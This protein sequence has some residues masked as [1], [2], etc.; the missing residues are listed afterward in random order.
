MDAFTPTDRTRVRRLPRRGVYDKAL[1]YAI[2]DE[3]YVCHVGFTVDAQPYVIPVV[4]GRHG[5]TLYIHGSA[6]ARMLRSAAQ[7]LDICV[8]VTLI[9]G[10][11]LARSAFHHSVNYRSVV[12]LGSA[13]L[14]MNREE[15]IE[16][17]RCITNHVV[18]GRWDQVRPP[19]E[20]ELTATSVLALPLE[21]VSAKIRTGPPIDDE[22]DYALPVWAGV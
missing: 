17:L 15:K 3:A 5:D 7:P 11:V 1:V 9:D 10:L 19:T 13:R 18:S 14:L 16:A 8:T 21:E 6:A 20:Q 22:E 4:Y 2:L 12:A